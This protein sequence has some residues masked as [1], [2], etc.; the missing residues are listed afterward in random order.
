MIL[1]RLV[2]FPLLLALFILLGVLFALIGALNWVATG[3][4]QKVTL[5]FR[6]MH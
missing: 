6:E 4:R 3:D 1:I 2:L 5:T